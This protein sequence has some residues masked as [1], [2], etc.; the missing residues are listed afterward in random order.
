MWEGDEVGLSFALV[1]ADTQNVTRFFSKLV[2]IL[3][4]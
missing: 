4:F 1:V 3:G 2:S